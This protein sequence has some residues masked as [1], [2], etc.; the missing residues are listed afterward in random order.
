MKIGK[1]NQY[2][3]IGVQTQLKLKIEIWPLEFLCVFL[4]QFSSPLYADYIYFHI[5]VSL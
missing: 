5:H 4:I 1:T 2:S 3:L